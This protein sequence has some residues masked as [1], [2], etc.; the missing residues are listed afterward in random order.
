M[1][2][3][4]LLPEALRAGMRRYIEHGNV[5]G[6]FL[7][8]V[9]RNDLKDA[10]FR[11]DDTNLQAMR[12]IVLFMHHEAPSDCWGSREKVEAWAKARAA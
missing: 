10:T 6:G 1:I 7:Q 5:P 4:Q 3:Y 2:N 12:D 11:A 8:A 9:L